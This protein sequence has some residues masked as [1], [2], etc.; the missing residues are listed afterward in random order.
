MKKQRTVSLRV[1]DTEHRVLERKALAQRMSMSEYIRRRVL[2]Y[3]L[4]F[5]WTSTPVT[6]STP[7]VGPGYT[8]TVTGR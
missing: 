3:E 1:D 2:A 4:P 8:L 5:D 6:T 7:A